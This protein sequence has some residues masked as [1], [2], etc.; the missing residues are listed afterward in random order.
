MF[1]IDGLAGRN[2]GSHMHFHL[3]ASHTHVLFTRALLFTFYVFLSFFLPVAAAPLWICDIFCTL[4][5]YLDIKIL[6]EFLVLSFVVLILIMINYFSLNES[7]RSL[8]SRGEIFRAEKPSV[9]L[10]LPLGSSSY[11]LI[12]CVYNVDKNILML[13]RDQNYF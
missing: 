5:P 2:Q 8:P 3:G 6:P 4:F 1:Y 10:Q 7:V 12:D 9:L 11:G 13:S